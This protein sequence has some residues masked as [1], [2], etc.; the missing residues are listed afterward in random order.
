LIKL[1]FKFITSTLLALKFSICV[2]LTQFSNL[3]F[4]HYFLYIFMEIQK[5]DYDN[6][7]KNW[8]RRNEKKIEEEKIKGENLKR[9]KI[10]EGDILWF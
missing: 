2:A 6:R 1:T 3:F 7:K 9:K 4:I 5:L 8:V 10:E